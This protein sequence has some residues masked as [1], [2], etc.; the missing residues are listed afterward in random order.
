VSEPPGSRHRATAPTHLPYPAY[1][2]YPTYLPH[3]T[4]SYLSATIG[5]MRVARSAG[6]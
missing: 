1:P 3:P 5:S 4:Y 2:T 6:R